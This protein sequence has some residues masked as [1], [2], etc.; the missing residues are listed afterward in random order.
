[1]VYPSYT[2]TAWVTPSPESN[3][4]PV[5]LPDAYNDNVACGDTNN[6]G[7]PNVSKKI[8]AAVSRLERGLIAIGKKIAKKEG[9]HK[10]EKKKQII[11]VS[12][13]CLIKATKKYN[14]KYKN[15]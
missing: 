13:N 1:M 10:K 2:G 4:T 8:S 5:V 9:N 14:Q 12:R 3:T 15:R 7:T 6:A 11:I